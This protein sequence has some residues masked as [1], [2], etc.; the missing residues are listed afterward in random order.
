M[1]EARSGHGEEPDPQL[2]VL[3]VEAR[4]F[5]GTVW[6]VLAARGRPDLRGRAAALLA[7]FPR[8]S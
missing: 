7:R 2:L 4:R 5:Q 8:C 3:L 1:A 6:T